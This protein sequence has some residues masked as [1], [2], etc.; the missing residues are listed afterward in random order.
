MDR[1]LKTDTEKCKAVLNFLKL[2]NKKGS[3]K[4]MF[5]PISG[6]TGTFIKE[7]ENRFGTAM[8]TNGSRLGEVAEHK[9]SLVV[10]NFK[11]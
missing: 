10:E 3:D 6:N 8:E 7:F 2:Y 5:H 9:T 1:E 4:K 11:I